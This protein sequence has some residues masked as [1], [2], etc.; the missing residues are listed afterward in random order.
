MRPAEG[1]EFGDID[2]F[3]H[4]AIRLRGIELDGAFEAYGLDNELG[5]LTDGEFLAGAYVDM[6]VADLAEAGDIAATTCAVVTIDSTIGRSTI[7][8]RTILLDANDVAE[9]DIEEYMD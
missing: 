5:E 2:E 1:V 6:A 3:T 8:Y 4:R 7:M 9:V